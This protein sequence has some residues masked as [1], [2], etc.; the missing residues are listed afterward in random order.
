MVALMLTL[1]AL[2]IWLYQDAERR[3]MNSPLAWVGLLLLAGPLALAL[4]WARRPLYAGEYRIGGSVWVMTR[5]FVLALSVWMLMFSAVL[6]V[7]LSDIMPGP[8]L[9]GLM[10]SIGLL[11]GGGWALVAAVLLLAAW[12]LRDHRRAEVGPTH[13]ALAG[14][15][16]PRPGDGLLRI[17]LL[18]GLLAVF[19]FTEPAHPAWVDAVE[20]QQM[21]DRM[22]L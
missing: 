11:F 19:I 22:M 10:L 2:A 8:V 6:A 7:W 12:L 17:I 15:A 4:Y 3:Q 18:A 5:V 14:L 1:A 9:V 20:W 16:L 21:P 13:A